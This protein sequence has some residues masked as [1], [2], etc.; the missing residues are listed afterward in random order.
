MRK[1]ARFVTGFYGTIFTF[2]GLIVFLTGLAIVVGS[3]IGFTFTH[4]VCFYLAESLLLPFS[5]M[6]IAIGAAELIIGFLFR[7]T[8]KSLKKKERKAAAALATVQ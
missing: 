2:V 3:A 5:V 1:R 8:K 7:K 6:L 4:N